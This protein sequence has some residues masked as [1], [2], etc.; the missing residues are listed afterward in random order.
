MEIVSHEKEIPARDPGFCA[1]ETAPAETRQI[2]VGE[3][4]SE[5]ADGRAE[6]Q[7]AGDSGKRK[8]SGRMIIYTFSAARA[9]RGLVGTR[10]RLRRQWA[11]R[12]R[13][14]RRWT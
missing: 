12:E 14:V 6:H 1:Q 13:R 11:G 8:S 2:A 4:A 9:S 3:A 7:T 10:R 5:A